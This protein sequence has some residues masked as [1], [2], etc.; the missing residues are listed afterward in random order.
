M[1]EVLVK[2]RIKNFEDFELLI[3]EYK[4]IKK[5]IDSFELITEMSVPNLKNKSII[6]KI[7]IKDYLFNECISESED[8]QEIKKLIIDLGIELVE[9]KY[10]W[11]DDL[12]KR[13]EKVYR[14]IK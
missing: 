1:E 5:R 9:K 3:K 4:S 13:F 12:K 8:L 6:D 11:S 10:S 7:S 14:K 2:F